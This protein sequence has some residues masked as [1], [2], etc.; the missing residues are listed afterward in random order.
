MKKQIV[1]V[2]TVLVLTLSLAACGITEADVQKAVGEAEEKIT[3]EKT[4]V[5]K[6][7][8]STKKELES[9]KTEIETLSGQVSELTTEK[10]SLQK[11]LESKTQELEKTTKEYAEYKDK[12]KDFETLS[13]AEAEARQIEADRIKAEAEAEAARK[14]EE[15]K[16]AKEAAEAEAARQAEEKERMGYETG[17][18]YS[19]L[20]R[21]PDEYEGEKVKFYGRVIQVID[22]G[23]EINLRIAV[24]GDYDQVVLVY[25]Q[26]DI[27][28]SRVL[29][30][31][32]ITIYGVSEGLYT[33]QSTMGGKIT[34]P[35]IY[36]EKIDQ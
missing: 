10:E 11:D 2:L 19:Q 30:D 24:D 1:L 27:V 16:A 4:K 36:V 26:K 33:Y 29:E 23:N 6:E 14:A 12:M 7:L 28:S 9:A 8:E 25:Y 34:V 13:A 18:T 5:E 3:A 21:T 32:Y 15:E 20:A 17:I 22:G 31:D 35:L